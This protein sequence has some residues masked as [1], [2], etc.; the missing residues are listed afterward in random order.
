MKYQRL[1]K[2]VFPLL[3]LIV[4]AAFPSTIRADNVVLAGFDLFAKQPGTQVN[5][6]SGNIPLRGVAIGTFNF[7][8]GVCGHIQYGHNRPTSGKRHGG[9]S[10]C[11]HSIGYAASHN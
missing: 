8:M 2:A 5:L 6:G 1:L 10:Y 11:S 9:K 3:T 4:F 7:G